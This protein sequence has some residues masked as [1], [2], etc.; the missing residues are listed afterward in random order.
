[1]ESTAVNRAQESRAT[2]AATLSSLGVTEIKIA[3]APAVCY[4]IITILLAFVINNPYLIR[5]DD[6]L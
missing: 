3:D 2:F 6:M 4:A 5:C 1:M